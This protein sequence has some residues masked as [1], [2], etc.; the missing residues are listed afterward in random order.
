MDAGLSKAVKKVFVELF[1]KG[2]IYKDKRLVNWDPKLL[3]AISDLEVEQKEK[4]G[5]LW[6][7]KYPINENNY[8]VVD[9]GTATNFDV[10]LANS[11]N[12]GV[13]APGIN[14]S[15]ENLSKSFKDKFFFINYVFILNFNHGENLYIKRTI[16]KDWAFT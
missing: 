1:K 8:I 16:N 3:T 10:I 9:F 5:S 12:G 11:Y 6:H 4:E 15:L 14:L 2:I 13:I 7:I